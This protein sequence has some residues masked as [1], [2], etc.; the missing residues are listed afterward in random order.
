MEHSLSIEGDGPWYIL[1]RSFPKGN[2]Q[3]RGGEEGEEFFRDD[4]RRRKSRFAFETRRQ[5]PPPPF[6]WTFLMTGSLAPDSPKA[7]HPSLRFDDLC[8]F[9]N[10]KTGVELVC[11]DFSNCMENYLR[12]KKFIPSFYEILMTSFSIIFIDLFLVYREYRLLILSFDQNLFCEEK[13]ENVKLYLANF[14][15]YNFSYIC[16]I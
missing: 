1:D 3:R 2:D 10:E 11:D 7:L 9:V 5:R 8:R 15:S 12:E 6:I 14:S 4:T 16:I 13:K